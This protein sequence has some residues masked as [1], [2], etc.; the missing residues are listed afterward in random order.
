MKKEPTPEQIEARGIA[1]HAIIDMVLHLFGTLHK[2][3]LIDVPTMAKRLGRTPGS[4][5]WTFERP[6]TWTIETVA[7]LLWAM[8]AKV[9]E[10]HIEMTGGEAEEQRRSFAYGNV[11]LSNPN[12]TREMID[13]QAEALTKEQA[14]IERFER[15]SAV[16]KTVTKENRK[17][18]ADPGMDDKS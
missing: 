14:F 18:L 2:D 10:L 3:G 5:N 11:A 13:E 6:Q 9:L 1:H 8:D 12:V 16:A 7:D 15:Q 4:I 17:A